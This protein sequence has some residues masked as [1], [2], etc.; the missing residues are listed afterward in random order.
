MVVMML[1]VGNNLELNLR[2][3]RIEDEDGLRIVN[4]HRNNQISY[5]IGDK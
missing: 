5:V 4:V 2:I 3:L 1:E